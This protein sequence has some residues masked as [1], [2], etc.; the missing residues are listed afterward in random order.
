MVANPINDTLTDSAAQINQFEE[1][2]DDNWKLYDVL[3][4]EDNMYHLDAT[5]NQL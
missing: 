2:D 5:F 3:V 1:V 4:E